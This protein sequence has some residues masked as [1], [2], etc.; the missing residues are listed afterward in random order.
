MNIELAI[1]TIN[2]E[3]E[4][5]LNEDKTSILEW[6]SADPQPTQ[7]ELDAAWLT[8]QEKQWIYSIEPNLSLIG[9]GNTTT[10]I[11]HSKP[12]DAQIYIDNVLHDVTIDSDGS[13]AISFTVDSAGEYEIKGIG[14]LNGCYAIIRAI[15]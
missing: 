10:V 13:A 11:I 14:N 2:P 9:V 6:R 7:A 5:L 15:I 1:W 8:Y 12:G 3:Y 4:Y